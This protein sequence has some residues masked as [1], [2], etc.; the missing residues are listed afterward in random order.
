[1]IALNDDQLLTFDNACHGGFKSLKVLAFSQRCSCV[2]GV[3]TPQYSQQVSLGHEICFFP[4]F[5]PSHSD[6]H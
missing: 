5:H 2:F 4:K 3:A 1:M 6:A